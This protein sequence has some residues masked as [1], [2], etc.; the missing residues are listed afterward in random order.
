MEVLVAGAYGSRRSG[1]NLSTFVIDENIVVD[2]GALFSGNVNLKKV[3]AIFITHCHADHIKDLPFFIDVF[4]F[5]N[6]REEPL[7]VYGNREIIQVLEDNIFNGKVWPELFRFR[8]KNG[9]PAVVIR[10]VEPMCEFSLGDY[11]IIPVPVNH[12]VKTTG[13]A[14]FLGNKGVFISGDT[15]RCKAM[16]EFLNSKKE[17]KAFFVDVSYPSIK[18]ELSSI[19]LHYNSDDLFR[20]MNQLSLP[21]DIRV[22]AYHLKY[23]FVDVIKEELAEKGIS[24]LSDGER[25]RI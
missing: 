15:Y 9:K 12:T 8:L 17:I 22:F 14:I 24:A 13:F 1:M 6:S 3:K 7:L 21:R 5:E 10:K 4:P 18:K 19:A 2:C 25:I 11:R 23:P 16:W 20:D